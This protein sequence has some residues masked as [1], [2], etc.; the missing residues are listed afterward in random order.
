MTEVVVFQ[1][2]TIDF[3]SEIQGYVL[4]CERSYYFHDQKYPTDQQ[5][6]LDDHF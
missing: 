5:E 1:A 2:H 4:S 6:C 3:L